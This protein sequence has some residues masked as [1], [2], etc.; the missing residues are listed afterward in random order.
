L[1]GQNLAGTY[2]TYFF[3]LA[4]ASDPLISSV[5]TT[6]VG[7]A[8]NFLSFFLLDSKRIGR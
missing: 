3:A 8:A 6:G 5:I 2:A 7:L 1:T 4:G